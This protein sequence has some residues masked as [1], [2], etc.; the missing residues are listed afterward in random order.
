MLTARQQRARRR[1]L[2]LD[3]MAREPT[4]MS[5]C[6][7]R[8]WLMTRQGRQRFAERRAKTRDSAAAFV[9]SL[10]FSSKWDHFWVFPQ[11]FHSPTHLCPSSPRISSAFGRRPTFVC[12][13]FGRPW[14]L[15]CE[16][17]FSS[18]YSTRY[19]DLDVRH[20]HI[21]FSTTI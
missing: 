6:R 7:R 13:G 3:S 19:F 8:I 11:A 12:L 1:S 5:G 10:L 2:Q 16:S 17:S 4:T 21:H 9:Y 14:V 15:H 18:I 20:Q